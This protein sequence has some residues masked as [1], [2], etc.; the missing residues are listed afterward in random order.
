M[1]LLRVFLVVVLLAARGAGHAQVERLTN[2]SFESGTAGW[3]VGA[4]GSAS[5]VASGTYGVTAHQ[6]AYSLDAKLSDYTRWPKTTLWQSTTVPL[7]NTWYDISGWIYPHFSGELGAKQASITVDWGDG[8]VNRTNAG[9]DSQWDYLDCAHYVQFNSPT[10]ILIY[11]EVYG[12]PLAPGD[13]ALFD[14][15]SLTEWSDEPVPEPGA[16]CAFAAFVV[17]L[18]GLIRRNGRTR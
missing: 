17:S 14:E 10:P 16:L 7:A 8:T 6:G 2:G 13:F 4:N 3:T 12:D 1:G 11:L 15:L 9:A 18:F 5:V